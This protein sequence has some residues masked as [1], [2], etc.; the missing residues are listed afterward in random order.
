MGESCAGGGEEVKC[1]LF[2]RIMF[3]SQMR[4]G[5]GCADISQVKL[6]EKQARYRKEFLNLDLT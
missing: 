3:E 5:M 6:G 2:K 4:W 1:L